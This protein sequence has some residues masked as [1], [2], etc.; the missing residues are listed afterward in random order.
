MSK[1]FFFFPSSFSTV[2]AEHP[3][4][5][6]SSAFRALF[7][8]SLSLSIEMERATFLAQLLLLLLSPLG[9]AARSS[10]NSDPAPPLPPPLLPKWPESFSL[11]YN[12]SLPYTREFQSSELV[13]DVAVHRDAN[14]RLAKQVRRGS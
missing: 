1:F 13:Y 4:F 7:L 5:F 3:T 9:A 10:S 11:S 8:Y 6:L 14:R 2:I 12:F